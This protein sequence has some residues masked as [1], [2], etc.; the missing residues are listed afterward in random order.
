MAEGRGRDCRRARCGR[1]RLRRAEGESCGGVRRQGLVAGLAETV[2]PR[3][4][5]KLPSDGHLSRW[6]LIRREFGVAASEGIAN[7]WSLDHL[8]LDEEGVPTLVEVKRSADTRI[9][10]EVVGQMLDYAANAVAYLDVE[11]MRS[12]FDARCQDEGLEADAVL[13][14]ALALDGEVT[15]F[16]DRVKTNL[17]AGKLRLVFVADEIP[18]ELQR[19]VEFLN[20][21]MSSTEVLALEV[22]QYSEADGERQTFVSR[23]IGRTAAA[24]QRKSSARPQVE[25]TWTDY[26][27]A[28]S[29]TKLATVRALFD[30]VAAEVTKRGLDWEAVFGRGRIASPDHVPDVGP[31]IEIARKY[32]PATG[33]LGSGDVS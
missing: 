11:K 15:E 14:D 16:W 1:R 2:L 32:Q 23:I 8:F 4:A 20:E 17:A 25:W 18:A 21:Q 13:A 5:G 28:L 12:V 24:R 3:R 31:A 6:V 10:R 7:R 19:I 9:R 26:A 22:K 33:P 27:D 29:D 30:A